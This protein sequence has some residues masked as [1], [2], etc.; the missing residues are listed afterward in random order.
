MATARFNDVT[1]VIQ[2]N[3]G[4][5]YAA[6]VTDTTY[7]SIATN[8]STSA[9]LLNAAQIYDPV[10]SANCAFLVNGKDA[11]RLWKG[12]GNT[13]TSLTTSAAPANHAGTSVIT[14][15]FVMSFY[16]SLWYAGEPTEPTGVYISDPTAPESFDYGG[17]LPGAAYQPYLIGYND[18]VAGG[19]ITGF[20]PIGNSSV[21]IYKESAIYR[22]DHIGYYG[23]V[24]PWDVV[25][26]SPTVGCVAP[27]S[28]VSFDSFHCFLGPDGVYTCD[29][30]S[31]SQRPISDNNPDLFEGPNAAITTRTTAVGVR[32][33]S[34]Y[35]LFYDNGGL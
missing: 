1:S 21:L 29:G 35:L 5:I 10:Q 24:G 9:L 17:A 2:Q 14:P 25:L 8:A 32:L 19:N 3:G 27:K 22:M 23:D 30:N 7:A 20:A 15:A 12:P 6:Q 34:R 13:C 31:V 4:T 16:N 11:P 33:S 28:L 18:G 26:V